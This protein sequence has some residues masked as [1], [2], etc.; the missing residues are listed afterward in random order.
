M[1]F[2]LYIILQ[3]EVDAS[4]MRWTVRSMN[5]LIWKKRL[6]TRGLRNAGSN[7]KKTN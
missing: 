5:T 3:L 6:L 2:F 7:R 4:S 1:A